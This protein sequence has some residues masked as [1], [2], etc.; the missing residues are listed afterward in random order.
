MQYLVLCCCYL[1]FWEFFPLKIP[2]V[3]KIPTTLSSFSDTELYNTDTTTRFA[4]FSPILYVGGKEA[5]K[6]NS[7]RVWYV[8]HP[9]TAHHHNLE[10]RE[11]FPLP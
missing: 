11:A 10:Q 2:V 9:L 5:T 8:K 4:A 3:E 1:K 6:K 7:R